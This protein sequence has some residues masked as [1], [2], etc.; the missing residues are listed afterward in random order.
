ML[1]NDQFPIE[2]TSEDVLGTYKAI[3][4][5]NKIVKQVQSFIIID[6]MKMELLDHFLKKDYD[7]LKI[8]DMV[9]DYTKKHAS[10][11]Y[12]YALN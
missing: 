7:L 2:L 3:L 12:D 10:K 11:Y 5:A 4:K 1:E 6:L 8:W 9:V